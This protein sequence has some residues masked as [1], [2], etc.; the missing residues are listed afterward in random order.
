[1]NKGTK[2]GTERLRKGMELL[3]LRKRKTST[4]ETCAL[5]EN[6]LEK[7][8]IEYDTEKMSKK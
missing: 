2:E 1:M 5:T 6:M 3:L 4:Y 7:Y 8:E